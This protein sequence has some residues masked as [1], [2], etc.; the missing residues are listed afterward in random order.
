ML[1]AEALLKTGYKKVE[2]RKETSQLYNRPIQQI[3]KPKR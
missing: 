2:K 3:K 1:P